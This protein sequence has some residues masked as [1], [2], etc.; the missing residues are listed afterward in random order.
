MSSSESSTTSEMEDSTSDAVPAS[1]SFARRA[2]SIISI[3]PAMFLCSLGFGFQM[4]IGQV[5]E[6]S[7]HTHT[8][9]MLTRILTIYI[10]AEFNHTKSLLCQSEL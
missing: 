8:H 1:R 2:L 7:Y 6:H 5:L 10:L 3:E 9:Q 4:I